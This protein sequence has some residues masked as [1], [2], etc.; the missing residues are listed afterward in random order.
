MKPTLIL[1][2]RNYA[3]CPQIAQSTLT[4]PGAFSVVFL[5][6]HLPAFPCD[7][8]SSPLL[9]CRFLRVRDSVFLTVVSSTASRLTRRRFPEVLPN[10]L[11]NDTSG[12]C[13]CIC[14]QSF[15]K[16]G[17]AVWSKELVWGHCWQVKGPPRWPFCPLSGAAPPWPSS[18]A[19]RPP[20]S[21]TTLTTLWWSFKARYRPPLRCSPWQETDEAMFLPSPCSAAG[22]DTEKWSKAFKPNY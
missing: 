11:V 18:T 17:K 21:T 7:H 14:S 22:L 20:W 15:A 12:Y 1:R 10:R 2:A 4:E 5:L 8:I 13:K 19:P 3:S 9:V 16:A 6:C